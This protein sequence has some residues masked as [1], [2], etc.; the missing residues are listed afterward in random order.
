M[1]KHKHPFDNKR[2]MLIIP[3]AMFMSMNYQSMY[4]Y[5]QRLML[6]MQVHWREEKPVAFGIREAMK[7]LNCDKRTAMKAFKIL[8]ERGFI[9]K[10]DESLFNSRTKSKARTW[11]LTWMPFNWQNPTKEWEKWVVGN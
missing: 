10:V 1:K 5:S 4:P 11:R 8:Q 2:G 3:L 6:L 7:L 9:V